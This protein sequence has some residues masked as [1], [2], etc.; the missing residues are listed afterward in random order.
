MQRP[1]APMIAGETRV[2]GRCEDGEGEA[3][4]YGRCCRREEGRKLGV[5]WGEGTLA[6]LRKRKWTICN[7]M[8][9]MNCVHAVDDGISN[10]YSSITV[11]SAP[12]LVKMSAML[13]IRS[14][15]VHSPSPTHSLI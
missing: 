7:L 11:M 1:L 12:F 6:M 14:T 8:M 5:G 13:T 15:N 3:G 4:G 9:N 10:A 2:E